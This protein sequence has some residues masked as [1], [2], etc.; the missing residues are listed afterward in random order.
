MSNPTAPSASTLPLSNVNQVS[1]QP[2]QNANNAVNTAQR[3]DLKPLYTS[4]KEAIG[5][6]WDNYVETIGRFVLG[7]CMVF[8]RALQNF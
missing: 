6:N 8:V 5:D 1:A 7:R 2:A 3:I 4:L